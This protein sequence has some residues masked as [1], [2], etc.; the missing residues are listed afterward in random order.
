MSE[1][2]AN[3][4]LTG[5]ANL[6]NTCFINS[7]MQV[8]SHTYEIN[9][10]LDNLGD[11]INETTD[12]VLLNEWNKLRQLMWSE[13]CVISPNGWLKAI[14]SVATEKDKDI[15][16]G[17]AQNDVPEFLLFIVDCF[18]NALKRQVKMTVKGNV[19]TNKDELAKKCYEM[20][21]GMYE[22][23]YSEVLKMFFGIHISQIT[24]MNEEVLSNHP[25]PYFML[26]LP[27]PQGKTRNGKIS[28]VDCLHAYSAPETLEGE[29]AWLNEESGEKENV[30]RKIV[31]WSLPDLLIISFKRFNNVGRKLQNLID[32]PIENL[33]LTEYTYA[34]NE[35]S[36]YD[37]YGVCN[38]SGGVMGG[39]YTA[40]VKN[41]NGH[42]YYFNDTNVS[43]IPN[44][45]KIVCP[46]AYCLFYRKKK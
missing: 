2:Y 11:D 45:E 36:V 21:I 26:D 44:P 32:F 1:K 34:Y 38:H 15:F 40:S 29:N 13:N 9:D 33:D 14:H 18:H 4:G 8:I 12:G 17:Y 27:V 6:G 22:K 23:E 3:K 31:F 5:M 42:W 10:L 20:V 24:N 37:L 43:K 46:Q 41:A 35:D 39:H 25:E 19:K 16:T 28:L 30:N 7:C